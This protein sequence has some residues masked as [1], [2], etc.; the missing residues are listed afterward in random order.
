MIKVLPRNIIR[1][2]VLIV[3]QIFIFNNIELGGYLNPYVYIIFI[4]LLP[5]ETPGW[6]LLILSFL[7]GFSVDIFSETLGMHTAASVFMAYLRPMA[8]SMFAPRDGY[9]SG[10]FPRIHYY[11][12]SWF[13]QYA[14]VLIFAH[15]TVLFLT[16]LFIIQDIFHILLRIVF[17]TIFSAS[18]IILSQFIVFKK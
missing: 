18:L 9:E 1:F 5:F 13:A 16:E 7:L 4:L 11:G 14:L 10:S 15:H 17:S 3:A 12:L 8:L 6:L 2:L